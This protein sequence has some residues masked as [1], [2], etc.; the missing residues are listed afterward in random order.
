MKK[1]FKW[2]LIGVILFLLAV[3]IYY[4]VALPAINIHA[5]ETWSMIIVA[6]VLIVLIATFRTL[7]KVK[8]I[9]DFKLIKNDISNSIFLKIKV[10]NYT[11]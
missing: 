9:Q 6:L 4:Y 5:K 2:K 3:G 10:T 1:S 8:N 7:M 11:Y